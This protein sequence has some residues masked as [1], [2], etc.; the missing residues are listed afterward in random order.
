MATLDYEL[1]IEEREGYLY[2]CVEAEEISFE[3]VIEYTNALV[4][5]LRDG[6]YSRLLLHTKTPVLESTDCY[7]IASYIVRNAISRDVKIAVVDSIPGHASRQERISCVSRTA[8][9]DLKSFATIEAGKDWLL[10]ET[11]GR[12]I[13]AH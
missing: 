5:R 4:Q 3:L 2:A 8:G 1:T 10:R 12:S 13:G 7:E 11:N 9:L 6:Q